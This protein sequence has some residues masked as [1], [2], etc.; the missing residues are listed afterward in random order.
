MQ[1]LHS[2]A[3]FLYGVIVALSFREALVRVGPHLFVP[4]EIE[5]WKAHL[6][7]VR[8]I[9]FLFAVTCF[10]F[11]SAV[12]FDKVHVN[13]ATSVK[14]SRKNYG[15][16]FALGLV[17]FLIFF[18]W[19]ITVT[20]HSRLVFGVGPFLGFLAA[21]LLYD[22][23]WLAASLRFDSLKEIKMWAA[24]GVVTFVAAGIAF[25]VA[26]ASSGNDVIAEYCS[27]GPVFLYLLGDITE[28]FSG[29]PFFSELIRRVLPE[30]STSKP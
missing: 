27:F 29:K 7:A 17:H 14:Y 1:L 25:F 10:Y 20:D 22:L 23:V 11:G 8:L 21:V 4:S 15:L 6:E 30:P 5:A 28:L 16:D 18:G 3:V 2:Y 12:F 26:K 9:L 19:A 13:S 24:M